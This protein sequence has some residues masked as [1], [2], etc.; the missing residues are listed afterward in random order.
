[1]LRDSEALTHTNHCL[2][3]DLVPINQRF[4]ELIQS[5]SRK[6]RID[7][8]IPSSPVSGTAE[9]TVDLEPIK[10][11]LRD[12]NGHPRSICRHAND[13]PETG[14]WSTVFSVIIEPDAQQMHVTRGTPCDRPYEVYAMG[15]R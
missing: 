11:A 14:F 1:M 15:T 8:L 13:D 4:P 12:H 2:H 5:H 10:T 7:T 3:P 6:R 9:H